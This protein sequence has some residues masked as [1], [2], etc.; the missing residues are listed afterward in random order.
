MS[1]CVL[2]GLSGHFRKSKQKVFK[3]NPLINKDFI[4]LREYCINFVIDSQGN[5]SIGGYIWRNEIILIRQLIIS[6]EK[7]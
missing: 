6:S 2:V 4:C 1:K 5:L 7:D 3:K